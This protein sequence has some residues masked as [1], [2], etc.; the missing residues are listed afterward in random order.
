MGDCQ[1]D[2]AE[3]RGAS[4]VVLRCWWCPRTEPWVGGDQVVDTFEAEEFAA[5]VDQAYAVLGLF[6]SLAERDGRLGGLAGVLVF[7]A[8][9]AGPGERQDVASTR[10]GRGE[11]DR[12]C[13]S[14]GA[15]V[16][17]G[18]ADPHAHREQNRFDGLAGRVVGEGVGGAVQRVDAGM[19]CVVALQH[20]REELFLLD[21]QE[22]LSGAVRIGRDGR[23]LI[24]TLTQ[25]GA[26]LGGRLERRQADGPLSTIA[27]RALR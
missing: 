27:G 6:A 22:L 9:V 16:P 21:A 26:Q 5:V 20:D 12:L 10:R 3:G 15:V 24:G 11:Q 2:A 19:V 25:Q 13:G 14:D 23:E 7:V 17:A 18:A 4:R 1:L 8:D